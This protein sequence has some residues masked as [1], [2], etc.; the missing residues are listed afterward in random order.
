MIWLPQAEFAGI[1]VAL[2]DGLY[3]K[4][5]VHVVVDH[6]QPDEELF[7]SLKKKKVDVIVDWPLAA[8]EHIA[9]GEKI[10]N[11]G[12]ITQRSALMLIAR[13]NLNIQSP[14]DMNGYRIG[15]WPAISLKSPYL[16]FFKHYN[17][18][19]YTVLP[20]LTNVDLFL[21]QG[22]DITA[23]VYY[24]EFYRLRASG[25]NEDELSYF[26][27]NDTFPELVDDGLYCNEETWLD[28][29]VACQK[30]RDATMEGWRRAFENK[31]RT[32][33]IV[34]RLCK[35]HGK[36]FNLPHQRWMLNVMEK[37][38]APDGRF[39]D[40]LMR[41]ETFKQCM[42]ILDLDEN[43]IRYEQ[44]IPQIKGKK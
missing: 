39:S 36:P 38:I 16:A 33:N 27:L 1:Y 9:H 29:P 5:G 17:I 43:T 3:E 10:V 30:I 44:F 23:G 40:G 22:I 13:K 15:L 20:I 24:D 2:V 28:D 18:T 7:D 11:I 19:D 6:A 41:K 26:Y 34:E 8:L 35:K 14:K 21:Y 37:I 32:L 42:S 12:Q 25:F 31:E 4:A